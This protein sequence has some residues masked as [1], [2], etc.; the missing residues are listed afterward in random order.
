MKNGSSPAD[1]LIQT[2][3]SE[4]A[5]L[6]EAAF[7][8]RLA[9]ILIRRLLMKILMLQTVAKGEKAFFLQFNVLH[10][11]P[12]CRWKLKLLLDSG[13]DSKILPFIH[14]QSGVRV[15]TLRFSLESDTN[16]HGNSNFLL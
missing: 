3:R 14:V 5:P 8:W 13:Y 9:Q 7:N 2:L 4:L 10:R 16:V 11:R 12:A 6:R 15:Q 1:S